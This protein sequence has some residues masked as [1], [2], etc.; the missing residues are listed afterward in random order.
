MK[1][2]IIK[3]LGPLASLAYQE[4]HIVHWSGDECRLPHELVDAALVELANDLDGEVASGDL[5][6]AERD[7]LARCFETLCLHAAALAFDAVDADELVHKNEHWLIVRY[8]A[9]ETLAVLGSSVAEWE[10]NNVPGSVPPVATVNALADERFR[11]DRLLVAREGERAML[12]SDLADI[13]TLRLRAARDF[14]EAVAEIMGEL[15]GLGHELRRI[16][17]SDA[18]ELWAPPKRDVARQAPGI[19]IDLQRS[20][21]AAVCWVSSPRDPRSN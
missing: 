11:S 19:S 6:S 1:A 20:G 10:R 21:V 13:L 3:S 9:I 18:R 15:W 8:V 17:G 2:L 7:A 14:D 16:E 5:S 4:R 12:L